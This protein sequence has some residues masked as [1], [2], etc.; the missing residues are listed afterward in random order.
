VPEPVV[1]LSVVLVGVV[2]ARGFRRLQQR[3]GRRHPGRALAFGAGLTVVIVLLSAPVEHAALERLWA[4]MVQHELLVTVAAPL[5][6]LGN[7]LPALMWALPAGY[8]KAV[9]PWWRKLSRSHVRPARWAAWAVVAFLLQILAFWA[10]HAPD[11]YQA[12][13]RSEWAHSFQHASFLGTALFF[14]WAVIGARRRSLYGGGVLA[15]FAAALQGIA[16]GAFMTFSGRVWYPFY[17]ERVGGSLTALE[18]QQ[19][20]GVIMWGPGGIAYLVAAVILFMAWLGGDE[21]GEESGGPR[22]PAV[23]VRAPAEVPVT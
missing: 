2:Y 15:N 9:A 23:P 5:I 16:L 8:R 3:T 14:W 6:I 1:L 10:W 4:H 20:A 12:A 18:D 22:R 17:A 11:L 19:V 7:P 21:A 13:L